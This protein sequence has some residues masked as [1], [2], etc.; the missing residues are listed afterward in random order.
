MSVESEVLSIQKKLVKMS[1]PDGT[2]SSPAA[3]RR[4]SAIV[5][6]VSVD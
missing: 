6:I 4:L 3:L 5:F 2:V 1:S